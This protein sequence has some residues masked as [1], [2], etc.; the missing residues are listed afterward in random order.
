MDVS[1]ILGLVASILLVVTI[2]A[3]VVYVLLDKS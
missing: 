1:I 3:L 2:M